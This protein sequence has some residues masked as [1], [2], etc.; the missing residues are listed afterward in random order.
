MAFQLINLENWERREFYEEDSR[1]PA[2]YIDRF[3]KKSPEEYAKEI[4]NVLKLHGIV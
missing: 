4:D 1:N 2:F 3:Y